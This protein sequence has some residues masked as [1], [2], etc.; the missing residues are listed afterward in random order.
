VRV[1]CAK[2]TAVWVIALSVCAGIARGDDKPTLSPQVLGKLYQAEMGEQYQ[3]AQLPTLQR[4]HDLIERYFVDPSAGGKKQIAAEIDAIKLDRSIVG[5]LARIRSSWSA[6]APGVYY[7]NTK[8]GPLDVRYF[9]G[10]PAQ[11][12]VT[13]SW[14]L[15][16]RLPV[17]NAFLT[18]PP[19]TAEQVEQIYSGWM[20]RELAAHPDAVVI[21]P[22]LNLDELYGPGPLGMNLVIQPMLDL[23]N[24]VN[25]DPSRV[26]MIGH[27]MAA[28]AVWNIA[29]HYPTYFTAINP[30]AGGAHDV[31][32]RIRLGN[33]GNIFC[34]VWADAS[35]DVVKADESREIVQYL[36]NMKYDID[37]T[38]TRDLGH[39][40]SATVLD[41]EYQKLRGRQRDLYPKNVYVQSNNFDTIFNRADWVQIYQALA[42]G[43]QARVQFARGSQ[44][45]YI[46]QNSFRVIGEIADRHTIKLTTRNVQ[47]ARI[48][49]NEQMVDMDQPV[50][51]VANGIT[52]FSGMVPQSADEMLKDQQFLGRGWRYYTGQVDLDLSGSVSRPSTAPTSHAPIEYIGPD[53]Q[54]HVFIPHGGGN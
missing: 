2:L 48:Y 42:P 13:K 35:D 39:E 49:L 41:D 8:N 31:Y 38:E 52:R 27:S 50:T 5:K 43:Q 33:L 10:I 46:Y 21:M 16:I 4:A 29:I 14:P 12:D 45:M 20:M 37:Y 19:P 34:V 11:Y 18:Q 53:G 36:R 15:V 32:Q 44:G 22:L 7:I 30:L 26:Y 17:A 28:N 6:I 51:I 54:K 23:A 1:E 9:L 40:P 25:I 47:L 3:P 24:R